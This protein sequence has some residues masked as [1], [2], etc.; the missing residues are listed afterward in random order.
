M[1]INDLEAGQTAIV[2]S[3]GGHG[4]LRQHFLDM[5]LIP[6]TEVRMLGAAPMGDPLKIMVHGYA[7]TL[8]VAEAREIRVVESEPFTPDEDNTLNEVGYNPNDHE[9]DPHPGFGEEGKYHSKEDARPLPKDEKLTFAL[10]GQ[11]NCG[12]TTMFNVLT[13]SNQHVGNFPGVTVDRKDGQIRGYANAIVTDLPGIYS[14]SPYTTEE[15]V[16]RRFILNER[17]KGIINIVDAS[18]IERHLYLTVQLMELGIPMVLAR[19]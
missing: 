4:A 12:K 7:L 15:L 6:G 10:A 14:L 17:P 13:G 16:S 5:G 8:R 3:V 19:I 2:D 18:N 1:S 9:E 11:Q